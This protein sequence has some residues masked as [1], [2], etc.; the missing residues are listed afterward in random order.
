MSDVD[1]YQ[2]YWLRNR[3]K[4]DKTIQFKVQ[5]VWVK[6]F[7]CSRLY[8]TCPR[9]KVGSSFSLYF[10]NSSSC[11]LR[12]LICASTRPWLSAFSCAK[13]SCLVAREDMGLLAAA[14]SWEMSALWSRGLTGWDRGFS[15]LPGRWAEEDRQIGRRDR[16]SLDVVSW[17]AARLRS[18][19]GWWIPNFGRGAASLSNLTYCLSTEGGAGRAPGNWAQVT[20]VL[21]SDDQGWLIQL[22]PR[23]LVP[24]DE[25]LNCL[26]AGECKA[27][28]IG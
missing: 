4:L 23:G 15:L 26:V 20:I 27:R 10:S 25:A 9:W 21:L 1:K 13:L 5:T 6:I 7:N 17:T 24:N 18:G 2:H 22:V 11:F 12:A 3:I 14:R 8:N 16:F 19:K 28:V